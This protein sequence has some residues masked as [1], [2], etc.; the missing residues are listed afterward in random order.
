MIQYIFPPACVIFS[1]SSASYN[2]TSLDYSPLGL[3]LLGTLC[4]S[5]T[6]ICIS[7]PRFIKF[8]AIIFANTFPSPFSCLL[9]GPSIMQMLVLLMLSQW[10]LILFPFIFVHLF[11]VQLQ[12]FPLICLSSC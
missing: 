9:L 3:I 11:S 12:Q 6:G 1:F 8:S 4:A 5:W 2:F 7:F 10:S